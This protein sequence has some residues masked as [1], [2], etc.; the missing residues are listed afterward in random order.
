MVLHI[1]WYPNLPFQDALPV[2]HISYL[3]KAKVLHQAARNR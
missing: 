2:L 3:C 1:S